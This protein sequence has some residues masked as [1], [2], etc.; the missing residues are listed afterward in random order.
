MVVRPT[1]PYGLHKRIGEEYGELYASLFGLEVYCFRYFNVFGPRQDAT[2]AYSGVISIFIDKV[3]SGNNPTIYGD[4]LQSRDFIA[5]SDVCQAN[6]L[7]LQADNMSFEVF[8]V[9]SGHAHSLLKL[10]DYLQQFTER[11]FE[12]EYQPDRR[13]DLRHSVSDISRIQAQLGFYPDKNLKTGLQELVAYV[14][15]LESSHRQ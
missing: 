14:Q 9:G 7:A 4:G 1:S 15:R 13:G 12:L 10:I 2:S 5:V 6:L 8:N 3:L 11:H